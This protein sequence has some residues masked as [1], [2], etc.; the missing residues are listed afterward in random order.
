MSLVLEY[1]REPESDRLERI[2]K[3]EELAQSKKSLV[4]KD[5]KKS[6]ATYSFD[7]LHGESEKWVETLSG[8]YGLNYRAYVIFEAMFR[9]LM[10]HPKVNSQFEYQHDSFSEEFFSKKHSPENRIELVERQIKHHA[11]ARTYG[12]TNLSFDTKEKVQK[13]AI[14]LKSDLK[15]IDALKKVADETEVSFLDLS[16]EID[17]LREK[18]LKKAESSLSSKDRPLRGFIK[19]DKIGELSIQVKKFDFFRYYCVLYHSLLNPIFSLTRESR[20]EYGVHALIAHKLNFEFGPRLA[21]V[22]FTSAIVANRIRDSKGLNYLD[23]IPE[24]LGLVDEAFY[25][26]I[27]EECPDDEFILPYQYAEDYLNLR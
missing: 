13:L 24:K 9:Q 1:E 20:M 5:K 25:E 4:G 27:L 21:G 22:K 15:T 12:V 18:A 7:Q 16:A 14:T 3:Y 11:F 6:K 17:I 2:R 8:K 19:I 23:D 26:F 10:M